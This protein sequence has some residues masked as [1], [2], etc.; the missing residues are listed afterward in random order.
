M[1]CAYGAPADIVRDIGINVQPIHCFLHLCL[2]LLHPLVGPTKVSKGTVEEFCGNADLASLH[3][4]T[5]LYGQIVPG[6][7]E[8]F[9]NPQDL[10]DAVGP[11]PEGEAVPLCCILSHV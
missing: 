8:V 9:G 2:H 1:P 5:S 7:P 3:E 10:L 11:S 6:A 4:N